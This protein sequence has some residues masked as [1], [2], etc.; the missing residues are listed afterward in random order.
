LTIVSALPLPEV[1]SLEFAHDHW[2]TQTLAAVFSLYCSN[3]CETRR[4]SK[5]RHPRRCCAT[6]NSH[7]SYVTLDTQLRP[8]INEQQFISCQTIYYVTLCKCSTESLP[9]TEQTE[10]QSQTTWQRLF[11]LSRVSPEH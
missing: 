8:C 6:L 5:S 3:Q 11:G 9:H 7:L 10:R 2:C 4:D 1:T